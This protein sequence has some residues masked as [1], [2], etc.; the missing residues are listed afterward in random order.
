MPSLK[1]LDVNSPNLPGHSWGGLQN[2][3][4][5]A[6]PACRNNQA[7]SSPC[8]SL[9]S[10]TLSVLPSS[11]TAVSLQCSIIYRV[12]TPAKLFWCKNHHWWQVL[13]LNLSN[14]TLVPGERL[15]AE[16]V[17]ALQHGLKLS[18]HLPTPKLLCSVAAGVS[19]SRCL[20][21][22]LCMWPVGSHSAQH[23]IQHC[24]SWFPAS[25]DLDSL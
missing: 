3:G 1:V 23:G 5:A 22:L 7:S 14:T 9:L 13:V 4:R 17:P 11:Q 20:T 2:T 12:C 10:L 19:A 18:Q 25:P 8:H 16:S 6:G 21:C 24:R 15:L